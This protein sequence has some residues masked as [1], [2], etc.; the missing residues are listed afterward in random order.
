[1]TFDE[2]EGAL[3]ARLEALPPAAQAE[4]IHLLRVPDLDRVERIRWLE[5]ER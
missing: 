1:V 2:I 3:R 4:L 5:G